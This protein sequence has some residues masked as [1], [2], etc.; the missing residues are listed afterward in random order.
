MS[1]MKEKEYDLRGRRRIYTDAVEITEDNIFEELSN[2]VIKFCKPQEEIKFL[3]DYEKGIQPLK[4]EKKIRSDIDIKVSDNVAN[5]VVEFKL[6]YNWGNPIIYVQRG[7]TD[8]NNSTE[9]ENSK[10]DTAVSMLNAMNDCEFAFAKDQDLARYVEIT[11]I[12]FQ[13][14][15]VKP[16]YDGLSAFDLVTLNPLS[17]F[18][19]YRNTAKQEKI[20]GVTFRTLENGNTYYTVFTPKKRFEIENLV[21]VV[22]GEKKSEWNF[23][24][25]S[26]ERNPFGKVPIV[27]F[28]RAADRTGVFERQISDMDALNIEVSDFANSVAQT[29]QEVFFGVGFDLPKDGNG[30]TRFRVYPRRIFCNSYKDISVGRPC[31]HF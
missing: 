29:T 27:E 30:K 18:C 12:G 10:Q 14:V 8:L 17:T 21:K 3:L 28:N 9:E 26:G 15:D 5:Q 7:N 22:N 24:Q 11:G 1:D 23:L 4:R 19:I 20:A 2:A 16:I 31:N 13:M 25:R 6:G